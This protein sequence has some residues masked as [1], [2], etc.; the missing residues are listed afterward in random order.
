MPRTKQ[1]SAN[2][3]TT[4]TLGVW[5]AY[6]LTFIPLRPLV[7]EILPALA[8][9]P[10]I[11][12]AWLFGMWAGLLAGLLALPLN[13]LLT[14]LAGATGQDMM[15]PAGIFGSTVILLSGVAV[16]WLH[17]LNEQMQQKLAEREWAEA[18][19]KQ[20]AI[21]LKLINEIGEQIAAVMNLDSVLDR[22]AHLVQESFGYHHVAL[23]TVDRGEDTLVM[24]SKAGDFVHLFPP[25]HRLKLGQGMVGWVSLHGKTLLANDVDAEP[26]YV[27][28]YPDLVPTRS[29]LSVPI[30]VGE[31][32]VG[33]L[34]IQ[35]PQLNGFDENDV[36]V[37]ETLADQIAVALDNARLYEAIQQELAERKRA[38]KQLQRYAAELEQSNEEIKQF[39]YIVSHDLRAPLVNLKGFTAEL[40]AALAVV[41]SATVAAL[42]HLDEKQQQIVTTALQEDIPE[43]LGFID[44][45]VTRMDRFINAVLKLSRLGRRELHPEPIDMNDLV[46]TIL[47]TLAHQIEAHRA[48]VTVGHLPEVIAD[49]TSMEQIVGNILS[50]A[51]KYLDPDRA[52]EIE[53]TA[54]QS[55]DATTFQIRDNGRGI[56]ERDM[57]KVF[58]PFRRAGKQDTPGEGMGLAYVQTLIRRHGGRIWV[59][60][61][62]GE[63]STFYFTIPKDKGGDYV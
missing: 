4:L 44:S 28:L 53:I 59:E 22:A 34:D 61:E 9:L 49:R 1:L 48:K 21:Q 42:P 14:T 30:R 17:D 26:R 40:R 15:T 2:N 35:S 12:T 60:S 13:A 55:H 19:L 36:M 6:I 50:N 5:V 7:G 47:E 10:V 45:S 43:A 11:V 39:A 46:Q 32:V 56:A 52:G 41:G 8:T 33:V 31:E 24:R 23:F 58:A 16:G 37:M 51:V 62:P 3:K 27:N 20:R 54:E 63:G 25:D 38:E 57:H 29:E 18:T